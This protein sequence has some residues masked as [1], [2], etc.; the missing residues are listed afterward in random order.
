MKLF[1]LLIISLLT[2][3]LSS[4]QELSCVDF[5]TGTFLNI[6]EGG[7]STQIVRTKKIQI[8]KEDAIKVKLKVDWINDCSYK[9]TFVKGNKAWYDKMGDFGQIPEITVRIIATEENS[10]TQ[11]STSVGNQ[12]F[13]YTSKMVKI[14]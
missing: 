2:C 9:L 4:A 1:L 11:E 10:Y 3:L 6:E 13:V 7:S 8:E 5:K 12:S 14:K